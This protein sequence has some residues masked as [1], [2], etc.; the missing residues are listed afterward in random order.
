MLMKEEKME[1]EYYDENEDQEYENDP[2]LN[3]DNFEDEHKPE[4]NED[5]ILSSWNYMF[6]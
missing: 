1:N 5:Y 4:G 2:Q 3:E 6:K